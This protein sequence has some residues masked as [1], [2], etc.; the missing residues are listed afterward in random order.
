MPPGLAGIAGF[1]AAAARLQ[2]LALELTPQVQAVQQQ[3]GPDAGKGQ[4]AAAVERFPIDLYGQQQHQ[5]GCQ[6]LQETQCGVG[7]VACCSVEAQ[8]G[9]QG[10]RA[11]CSQ[12]QG[13]AVAPECRLAS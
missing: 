8:Q 9:Y 4:Q 12:P 5:G 1:L 3:A 6:V 2:T 13:L 7:Q 10:D 11:G